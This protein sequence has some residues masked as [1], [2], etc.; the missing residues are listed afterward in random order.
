MVSDLSLQ[1]GLITLKHLPRLQSELQVTMEAPGA[2]GVQSMKL[3]GY[4]VRIDTAAEKGHSAVGVV[5]TD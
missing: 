1:G 4:V 5:F 2:D 3:R